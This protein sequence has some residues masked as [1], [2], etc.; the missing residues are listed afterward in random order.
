M[1]NHKRLAKD[2]LG[3]VLSVAST[4]QFLVKVTKCI[5]AISTTRKVLNG[6]Y[7]CAWSCSGYVDCWRRRTGASGSAEAGVFCSKHAFVAIANQ[8][9]VV[10]PHCRHA[11][12]VV[13]CV[14]PAG[15]FAPAACFLTISS[16][17]TVTLC[18]LFSANSSWVRIANNGMQT[19]Q[20]ASSSQFDL[21]SPRIFFVPATLKAWYS[22]KECLL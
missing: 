4:H 10:L 3:Q 14:T 8:Q 13:W 5:G 17:T 12:Q 22:L 2:H 16:Y 9:T 19:P 21:I 20:G 7:F 11:K 1:L 15:L 18:E 6:C